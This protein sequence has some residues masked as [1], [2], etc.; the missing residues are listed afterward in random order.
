MNCPNCGSDVIIPT[1]INDIEG[2]VGSLKHIRCL[3][4]FKDKQ[5]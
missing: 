1:K 4:R 5:S 2:E 3:K